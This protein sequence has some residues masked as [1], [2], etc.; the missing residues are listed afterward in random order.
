ME[1]EE[2]WNA[3]FDAIR[4]Q[5]SRL[6]D[7]GRILIDSIRERACKAAFS[8]TNHPEFAGAVSDDFGLIAGAAALDL[9]DPFVSHLE[10]EYLVGRFPTSAGRNADGPGPPGDES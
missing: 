7:G 5:E 6:D 1:F 2:A 10:S 9:H 4:S 3:A 8:A